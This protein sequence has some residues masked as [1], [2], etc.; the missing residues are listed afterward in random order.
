AKRA[1]GSY[2]SGTSAGTFSSLTS[3]ETAP[4]R[5]SCMA[6]RVG[7]R[8]RT[9]TRG[10]APFWSCL[11]RCEATVMKRNLL[12]TSLGRINCG[13]DCDILSILL[14]R[15]ERA[16]Y[17]LRRLR[18]PAGAQARGPD[19]RLQG[20]HRRLQ[21]HIDDGVLVLPEMRHLL[22]GHGQAA[23]ERGL[24]VGPPAAQPPLQVRVRRRDH[25]D[26]HRVAEP[27]DDLV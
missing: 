15:L 19:H 14:V 12:S 17:R 4:A 7:L 13:L 6:T 9:S 16:Q 22:A 24:V 20:L 2:P 1:S 18:H 11:A 8:L 27:L 3:Q 5:T 26:R 21:I 23:L 25:E 10:L